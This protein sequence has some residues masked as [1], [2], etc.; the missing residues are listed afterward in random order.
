MDDTR[1]LSSAKLSSLIVETEAALT[2]LKQEMARRDEAAQHAEIDR[3]EEHMAN[4][5]NGLCSVR[6]FFRFLITEMRK[7]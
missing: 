4:C 7:T 2:E 3:L 6:D 1:S 5:E